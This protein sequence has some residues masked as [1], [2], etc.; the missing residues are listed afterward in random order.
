MHLLVG[1]I[2]NSLFRNK[3]KGRETK[4]IEK[5]VIFF[6]LFRLDGK[7]EKRGK[8]FTFLSHEFKFVGPSGQ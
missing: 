3:E 7:Q 5:E 1:F 2:I 8:N 6:S 4:R